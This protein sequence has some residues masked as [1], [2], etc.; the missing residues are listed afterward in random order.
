MPPKAVGISIN[1]TTTAEALA[2]AGETFDIVLAMEVVEHVADVDFFLSK[3]AQ[4]VRPGGVMFIGTINR[5]RKAFALAIVAAEY[6]LGWAPRGSHRYEK[7]VRPDEL[8][9]PLSASGMTTVERTG[10][11][12]NPL[13]DSW[14]PSRDLDVNYM[15]FARRPASG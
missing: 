11:S 1:R 13:A 7:L 3:C 6:V 9:R 12:Y 10:V 4:M 8:D 5:T 2:D 15:V 14:G